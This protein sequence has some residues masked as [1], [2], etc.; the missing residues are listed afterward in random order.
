MRHGSYLYGTNTPT[1]DMDYK[2]V[3]LPSFSDAVLGRIKPTIDLSTNKTSTKNTKDDVDEQ[4]YSLHQFIKMCIDGETIA[5]DMLHCNDQNLI[6]TSP[7]WEWI[8]NRRHL[9][10]TKNMKAFLGYCRRQAAKYGLKGSRL[11]DLTA[12]NDFLTSLPAQQEPNSVRLIEF[13]DL[14]PTGK[15]LIK[16]DSYYEVLG[17]KHQWTTRLVEFLFRVDSEIERYGE[18]AK[19]AKENEGLDWKALH[20]AVRAAIQLEEIY[21]N[22]E[23]VYPL[24]DADFLIQIKNGDICFED[25][26]SI[27]EHKIERVEQLAAQSFYPEKIEQRVKDYFDNYIVNL[28]TYGDKK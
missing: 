25:V 18:R 7:E 6:A 21:T 19:Q 3:Y 28:Y 23:I 14:L 22:G 24:K 8:V 16:T 27:L 11:S 9:F 5:I 1:S 4:Y 2:G 10:Y 17:K 13:K 15:Y 26:K 12:V 20:H